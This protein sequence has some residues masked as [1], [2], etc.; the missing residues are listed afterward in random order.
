M[1]ERGYLA[2]LTLNVYWLLVN[3]YWLL[4]N[5]YWFLF[6]YCHNSSELMMFCHNT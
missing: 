1:V 6:L 2:H 4:V 3:G 5:G